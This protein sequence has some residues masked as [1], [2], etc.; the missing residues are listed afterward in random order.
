MTTSRGNDRLIIFTMQANTC[1]AVTH[2]QE[3]C[4]SNLDKETAQDTA[5]LRQILMQV[6]ASACVNLL[7][8]SLKL[9]SN[10][11]KKT[12]TVKKAC[13]RKHDTS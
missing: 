1:E 12:C 13:A 4:I 9:R 8:I 2:A 6:R 7:G 11:C 5:Y 10:R 3:T